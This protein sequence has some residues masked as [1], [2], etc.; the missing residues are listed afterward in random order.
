MSLLLAVGISLVSLN[1]INSNVQKFYP[2][3]DSSL[4]RIDLVNEAGK[5]KVQ[6]VYIGD[7]TEALSY[8]LTVHKKGKSGTSNNAQSGKFKK[9][10]AEKEHLLSTAGFNFQSGDAFSIR[11]EIY[12]EARQ[13][14]VEILDY[15]VP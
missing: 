10:S 9:G 3:N 6:G 14:S 8:K 13:L 12:Q 4:T 5:I 11:L 2:E 7:N 1:E 15:R